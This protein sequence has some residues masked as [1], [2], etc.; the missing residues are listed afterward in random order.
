MK[1]YLIAFALILAAAMPALAQQNQDR[2]RGTTSPMT[3]AYIGAYG[4]YNWIDVD[5]DAGGGA[6]P[7]GWDGG[8]FVGYKFDRLFGGN[9]DVGVGGTAAIEAFYG[10][11]NI[12]DTSGGLTVEKD[13]EWGIS[14]RPGLSFLDR[15]TGDQGLNP[16]GIIGYR[17]TKFD[18]SGALSGSERLDGFELGL[19]TELVAFR[20]AGLRL[21]YS[22]VW[23]DSEAGIDPDMDS[24][25]LGVTYHF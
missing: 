5:S 10:F 15:M 4:A 25:R 3:G 8:V 18:M 1:S 19:G 24:V 23:Y 7:D 2:T 22:H 12:D 17:N 16:Y 6:D 13:D 21:E 14:F 20:N 11:S 9:R